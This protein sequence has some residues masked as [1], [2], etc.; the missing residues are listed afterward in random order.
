MSEY[1][2]RE[3]LETV[4]NSKNF[5]NWMYEEIFPALKGDI[6]EIGS[7][8]GTYSKR[9]IRDFPESQIT[10]TEIDLE[11]L[12]NLEKEFSLKNVKVSKLDLNNKDDFEKIGYEKFDTIFGLNVLEHVKDDEFALSQLYKMLKKNGNLVILVPTHKFLFNVI[13]EDVGHWRRYTKKEL[14]MK[15]K[16][17]NFKVEKMFSFNFLGIIGWYINGNLCKNPQV[18]PSATQIFDKIIPIEK[19]LERLLGKKIGLSIISYSKKTN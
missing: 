1:V 18:N 10:L 5:N 6:L 2:G 9:I 19:H 14:K 16:N 8:K 4:A 12:K 3:N 17:A 13:D 7:G 15:L 11:Y